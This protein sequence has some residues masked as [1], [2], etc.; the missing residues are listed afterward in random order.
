VI[1]F[2]NAGYI[3]LS[4]KLQK[5][6]IRYFNKG[7]KLSPRDYQIMPIYLGLATCYRELQD[8][9]N[10]VAYLKKGLNYSAD[11]VDLD[12]VIMGLKQ[13]WWATKYLSQILG[14]AAEDYL[15]VAL[16]NRYNDFKKLVQ[17]RYLNDELNYPLKKFKKGRFAIYSYFGDISLNLKQYEESLAYFNQALN[18]S[19]KDTPIFSIYLGIGVCYREL[20]DYNKAISYLDK[21]LSS[22]LV[23]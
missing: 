6:A 18:L 10:A 17:V 22:S 9:D 3:A 4:F 13:Y 14:L 7:L 19:T 5:E 11:R 16:I 12:Y 8:H 2:I 1:F 20:T 15:Y 21:G 23:Q